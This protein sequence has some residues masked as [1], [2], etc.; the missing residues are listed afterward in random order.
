MPLVKAELANRV[1]VNQTY[2][3]G[4]ELFHYRMAHAS[5]KALKEIS[6]GQ[7][8]DGLDLN[9]K[10]INEACEPCLEVKMSNS[11]M[12]SRTNPSTPP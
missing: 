11:T 10:P 1:N 4:L 3:D 9:E 6:T 5:K 12:H 2:T 8:V 7:I